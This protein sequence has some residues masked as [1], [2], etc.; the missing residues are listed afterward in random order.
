MWKRIFLF[1]LLGSLFFAAC[2]KEK[3]APAVDLENNYYPLT[4]GAV[5]IYAVDSTAYSNFSN[6]SVNYQFQ[7]KDSI[8]NTFVDLAGNTNYRVERYKRTDSSGPWMIQKVFSR[9]KSLR[10][11]EESI[12]NQQFVRLIFPP[13]SGSVW[14][15]NAKN[16]LG[17]QDY[18]IN[19]DATPLTVNNLN[20]DSTIVVN[21]I[22][23]SN[24]IREDLVNTTYARN[25]GLIQKEV[26]AV[27]KDISSGKITNGFIYS[28]KIKSFK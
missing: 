22:N 19:E 16:T 11:G 7:I 1:I 3:Y 12:D 17:A 26:T 20:F 5:F 23:E 4:V 18:T 15:G 2:N 6:T 25:V 28:L 14:N 13:L 21:E 24:L 9:T 8:T 10:D 27:D